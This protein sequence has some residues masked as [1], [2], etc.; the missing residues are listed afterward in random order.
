[1]E[2]AGAHRAG[3]AAW[4]VRM[5]CGERGGAAT[6]RSLDALT[7]GDRL[8]EHRRTAGLRCRYGAR[9]AVQPRRYVV[10][11]VVLRRGCHG[12]WYGERRT[13]LGPLIPMGACL[14]VAHRCLS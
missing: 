5:V 7:G 14:P 1:M 13:P 6:G 9:G 8:A 12:G 4:H 10:I 11:P 2:N 3:G